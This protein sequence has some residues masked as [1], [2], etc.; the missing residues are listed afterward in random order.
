MNITD[1]ESSKLQVSNSDLFESFDFNLE[2]RKFSNLLSASLENSVRMQLF[3]RKGSA[4]NIK[5]IDESI[6][7][8]RIRNRDGSKTRIPMAKHIIQGRTVGTSANG[9][10]FVCKKYLS[11]D[12]STLYQ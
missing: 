10:C 12:W 5:I 8:E 3:P 7:L 1:R 9:I 4:K 11:K 6:R 2:V